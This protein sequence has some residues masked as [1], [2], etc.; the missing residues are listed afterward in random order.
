VAG[1]DTVPCSGESLLGGLEDE[2]HRA[3]E[4]LAQPRQNQRGAYANGRVH[5]VSTQVGRLRAVRELLIGGHR[6]HVRPV[7][8]GPA[9]TSAAENCDDSV[10]ADAGGDV[11]TSRA[12]Q[13]GDNPGCSLLLPGGL[14][15]PVDVAPQPDQLRAFRRSHRGAVKLTP[16]SDVGLSPPLGPPHRSGAGGVPPGRC[17][18]VTFSQPPSM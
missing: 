5:V 16:R 8:D 14:G 9:A 3:G 11:E 6:V 7:R 1:G 18:V 10:P 13:L 2:H 4:L 17:Q 12:K 15:V